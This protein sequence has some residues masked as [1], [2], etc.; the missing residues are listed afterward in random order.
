MVATTLE[1]APTAVASPS[2]LRALLLIAALLAV[3]APPLL[4][5]M[6][7][8]LDYPNHY[9]RLWLLSGGAKLAPLSH[10]YAVDWTAAWTNVGVDFVS[11]LFGPLIPVSALGPLLVTAATVLPPLGAILL[12]QRLF[13]GWRWWQVGIPTAAWATT[14]LAGLL[15]YQIG[16]GLAL[17]AAASDPW[18]QQRA[19]PIQLL[20]ARVLF[21]TGLLV[22]HIFAL[23]F[24]AALLGGLALGPSLWR[25]REAEALKTAGLQLAGAA[26]AVAAPLL[27]YALTAP[28]LPGGGA[29]A[30]EWAPATLFYKLNLLLCAF[31]TYDIRLDGLFMGV[32]AAIAMVALLRR[33]LGVHQGLLL[34]AVGLAIAALL[35]PTRAADTAWIDERIPIMALLTAL[36]ALNPEFAASGRRAAAAAG[37]LLVLVSARA[38]W[39]GDV[40]S[41]RQSDVAAV[42]RALS[43][44]PAGAAVL[45][46]EHRPSVRGRAM[47]PVGRYFHF[48]ASFY[49][50]YTLA[51]IDRRA[52][53]PLVFTTAGKQ[54]LRVLPPWADISAPN[55]GRAPTLRVLHRPSAAWIKAQPYVRDWRSRFDYALMLNAD[56]LDDVD[57]EP[58]PAG[59]T[60]L[61]DE[62]FARLYRIDRPRRPG[63]AGPALTRAKTK[64]ARPPE[65]GRA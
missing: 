6:P 9:V 56:V 61:D 20:V 39:I 64:K 46:V 55:G 30:P 10:M 37:A 50:Q 34:A 49:H 3:A 36:A 59:M 58:L 31:G 53:S 19:S 5:R 47:A 23:G 17:I 8:L 15:N 43:H 48:G 12:H 60:L 62:G 21:A 42:E 35:A 25:L 65:G 63:P 29:L 4:V 52:Y 38:A 32:L 24:Y 13:G 18:L 54:P 41:Q 14:L 2:R 7:P 28:K 11:Q 16:L 22:V 27:A 45:P 40:W 33:S 51:V 44:V 1:S 26:A 57:R